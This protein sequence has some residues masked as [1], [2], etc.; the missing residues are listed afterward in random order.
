MVGI[1]GGVSMMSLF[2]V[3]PASSSV[4]GLKAAARAS[5]SAAR[6]NAVDRTP[7]SNA[8]ARK[9]RE[10]QAKANGLRRV[11]GGLD[12]N[13]NAVK[14]VLERMDTV[15]TALS[16]L[17]KT[18]LQAGTAT[19]D[20]QRAKQVARF[21]QLV[22][23]INTT[24]K[25]AGTNGVNLIGSTIRDVFQGGEMLVKTK[26]DSPQQRTIQGTYL[27]SDFY[28]ETAAGEK[29]FPNIFGSLLTK[30]PVTDPEDEG[31]LLKDASTIAY[32]R[33]TG[34]ISITPEGESDPVLEGT[35][36]K[37]GLGVLFSSL[38]AKFG[39]EEDRT[40]ALEDI[41]A[42]AAKLRF[43]IGVFEGHLTS[44]TVSRD[45]VKSQ[46]AEND[47]ISQRLNVEAMVEKAKAEQMQKRQDLLFSSALQ[48]TL[49][50]ANQSGGL[51]GAA[52]EF[53]GLGGLYDTKI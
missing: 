12:R 45:S 2:G 30:I 50:G 21:D 11:I 17:R 6:A 39:T 14:K 47:R 27:G 33:E 53:G 49:A 31:L 15:R 46:I 41:D 23:E 24:V 37:Q 5:A 13:V 34:A 25:Y 20:E 22:G 18:V 10:T 44:V 38:Y 42:A 26:P 43:Q 7:E 32:D 29:H 19:T 51:L 35:V 36:R 52:I 8:A 4:Q 3:L 9:V 48:S 16:D 1:L 40:A 28:I